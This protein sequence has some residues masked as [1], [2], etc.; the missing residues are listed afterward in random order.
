M[1]VGFLPGARC[2]WLPDRDPS[3]VMQKNRSLTTGPQ[4]GKLFRSFLSH[5]SGSRQRFLVSCRWRPAP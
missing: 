3:G 1:G 2:P 4:I 5:S